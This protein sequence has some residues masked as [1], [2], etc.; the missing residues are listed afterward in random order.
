MHDRDNDGDMDMT[1]ID[2]LD[3]L[4]ILFTNDNA[5]GVEDENISLE[6]FSLSQNYPNP[7]NPSTKIK[8]TIPTSPK[9][10]PYQGGEAMQ[11]WLVTLKIY[12]VL[13]NEVVFLVNEEKPAG[14]YEVEFSAENLSSGIYY[15]GIL[16]DDFADIKKMLLLK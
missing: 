16:A 4:L 7:F 2:E 3:D 6:K 13:G 12:D 10:P 9:S 5:V 1:G 11:E 8:F 15:Y 14:E